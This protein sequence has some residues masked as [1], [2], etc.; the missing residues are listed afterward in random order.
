MYGRLVR[1]DKQCNRREGTPTP[2]CLADIGAKHKIETE[3][4]TFGRSYP[5]A[6]LHV[7]KHTEQDHTICTFLT[8]RRDKISD[9][10]RNRNGGTIP[11][12]GANDHLIT[13]SILKHKTNSMAFRLQAN[14]TD[15]STAAAGEV[16]STVA[17]RGCCVVSA[18]N[19]YNH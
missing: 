19:P 8:G 14:Y 17:G 7:A 3:R 12:L 5:G 11:V 18:K 6:A 15:G 13:M 2:C 1:H 9:A 10:S 16:V 4:V